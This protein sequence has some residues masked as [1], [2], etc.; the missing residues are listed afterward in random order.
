MEVRKKKSEARRPRRTPVVAATI[1]AP[2][3][4]L[5]LL[6]LVWRDVN[7]SGVFVVTPRREESATFESVY[8]VC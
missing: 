7:A 3:R 4:N 1:R 6:D 5:E 8:E 2:Q